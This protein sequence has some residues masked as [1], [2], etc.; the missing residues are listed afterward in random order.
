MVTAQTTPPS[1]DQHPLVAK[2]ARQRL[3]L[4]ESLAT[5]QAERSRLLSE[6]EQ[7]LRAGFEADVASLLGDGDGSGAMSPQSKLIELDAALRANAH[8]LATIEAASER[9]EVIAQGARA[10]A[11]TEVRKQAVTAARRVV[12][13]MLPLVQ[14]LEQMNRELEALTAPAGGYGTVLTPFRPLMRADEWVRL[15]K[16]FVAAGDQ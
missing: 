11:E 14:Q 7:L 9:L 8:R 6:R 1:L 2:H 12:R 4:S 5:A 10:A 3:E 13:Q 16:A 15:A